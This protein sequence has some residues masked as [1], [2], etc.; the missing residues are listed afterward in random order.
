[1]SC[2]HDMIRAHLKER[3]HQAFILRPI[4]NPEKVVVYQRGLSQKR[5]FH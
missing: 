2:I 5:N 3:P 1:M 4:G